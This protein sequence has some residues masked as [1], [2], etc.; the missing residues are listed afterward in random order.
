M[1][2][3]RAI[4]MSVRGDE[5]EISPLG[6]GGCGHCDSEKGCGSGK[7]TKMFC[8]SEVR[9]FLV[10]NEL[11]A[12]VGDEVN[13]SLPEGALLLSSWRMYL[14][15]LLLLLGGGL[16]GASL[17]GETA[18]RDGYALMGSMLGLV[19]GFVWGRF[20][21]TS[22]KPQAVVQSIISPRVNS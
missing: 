6:G 10:R 3:M 4:V 2:E 17:A 20:S 8:S 15:P 9:K 22:D 21:S 12:Q 7:L 19:S 16:M 18:S 11:G 5:A 13:V 1:L 14:L